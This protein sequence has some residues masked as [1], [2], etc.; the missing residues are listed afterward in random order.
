MNYPGVSTATRHPHLPNKEC[1]WYGIIGVS[2]THCG[3]IWHSLTGEQSGGCPQISPTIIPTEAAGIYWPHQFLPTV[4][5]PWPNSL[6]LLL[7]KSSRKDLTW[8]DAAT[9]AF[10]AVKNALADIILLVHPKPGAPTCIMMDASDAAVGAVL[11]QYM[12]GL[13]LPLAYFSHTLK[14]AQVRYSIS[15]ESCLYLLGH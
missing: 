4:C 1:V 11:Q 10:T 9:S 12:N 2:W 8:T 14:P 6:N 3:L 5:T 13:W 15:T 7:S